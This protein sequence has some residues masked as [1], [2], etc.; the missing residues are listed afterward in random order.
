MPII[1]RKSAFSSSSSSEISASILLQTTTTEAPAA[2]TTATEILVPAFT[3]A[4][5][6]F[7][8]DGNTFEF[9]STAQSWAGVSNDNTD[10]YPL[11]FNDGDD[12]INF[13]AS[14]PSG[15]D[16]TIKFRFEKNP[17]PDVNPAYDTTEVTVSGADNATYQIDIPDQSTNTY[18]SFLLYVARSHYLPMS[19]Q[20]ISLFPI[21]EY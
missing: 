1:S 19:R 21:F 10:I 16:V 14:V 17:Y 5:D 6:G 12:F 3:A 8:V 2:T 18:S 9:P 13:T 15:G 11:T 20:F 4:F 7:T